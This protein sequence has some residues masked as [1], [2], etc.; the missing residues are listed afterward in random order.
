MNPNPRKLVVVGCGAAGLA[1]AV[2]A[3][4]Q[5]RRRGLYIEVTLL[6]KSG[7][8]D[9]GG[10][11]R[12]SPSYMRM[13]APDLPASGFEDDTQR[14]SSGL[15]DRDYFRTLAENAVATIGWLETHGVTFDAPIYYLSAGPPRIQPIGGG[16]AIIEKLAEA[17]ERAGVKLRYE[18]SVIR[19]KM[20]REASA[21][22]R[23]DRATRPS[24]RSTPTRSSWHPVD[25]R[26]IHR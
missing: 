25:F 15:A 24:P 13:A 16:R 11:T 8:A 2:S 9:A 1:A 3:V 19:L 26:A 7:E 14:A 4:E 21:A 5:A 23:C 10:N 18:S 12:W 20:G 17:A 22:S 6:E